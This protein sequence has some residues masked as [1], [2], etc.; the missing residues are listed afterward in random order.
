MVRFY[1]QFQNDPI[2]SSHGIFKVRLYIINY[3]PYIS[4]SLIYNLP[5]LLLRYT[6]SKKEHCPVRGDNYCD[7]Y[8]GQNW[9]HCF[10]YVY[11]KYIL[12]TGYNIQI[13]K[14]LMF[15]VVPCEM[16]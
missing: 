15:V 13:F 9:V 16:Y 10:V 5:Q 6:A 14:K 3:S 11:I 1:G 2:S 8:H 4:H 12:I 7:E